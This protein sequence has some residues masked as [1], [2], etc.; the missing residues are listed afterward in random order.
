MSFLSLSD[1]IDFFTHFP[2]AVCQPLKATFSKF[3]LYLKTFID[4]REKKEYDI[5]RQLQHLSKKMELTNEEN[6]HFFGHV[7]KLHLLCQDKFQLNSQAQQN[8]T[9]DSEEQKL[10]Q[11]YKL[12]RALTL[13]WDYGKTFGEPINPQ[14]PD[15]YLASNEAIQ[16]ENA[17]LLAKA[18]E[19]GYSLTLSAL[20]FLR[21]AERKEHFPHLFGDGNHFEKNIQIFIR[22]TAL[23]SLSEM[24]DYIIFFA[25]SGIQTKLNE[26]EI[27]EIVWSRYISAA[28]HLKFERKDFTQGT[29]FSKV[30]ILLVYFSYM[31]GHFEKYPPQLILEA[32][33]NLFSDLNHQ[34]FAEISPSFMQ[35]MKIISELQLSNAL[36][37]YQNMN[38]PL[39]V[40]LSK[41]DVHILALCDTKARLQ[42]KILRKLQGLS[43][44]TSLSDRQKTSFLR[45][46][47]NLNALFEDECIRQHFCRSDRML[48]WKNYRGLA[49]EE[50]NVAR[51]CELS[52]ILSLKW[53]CGIDFNESVSTLGSDFVFAHREAVRIKNTYRILKSY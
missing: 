24:E 47:D 44:K 6:R 9:P 41:L 29:D 49:G 19:M 37:F 48:N 17:Y 10:A 27:C 39:K 1:A 46:V 50:K 35:D 13:K 34:S 53:D 22:H 28:L 18:S 14:D 12:T 15:F 21:L 7:D 38:A 42:H 32:F 20:K 25:R 11:L 40:V 3:T 8:L 51:L 5:F 26:K 2:H 33:E 30:V 36:D 43:K 4:M 31:R 52:E 45:H 16:I 23:P